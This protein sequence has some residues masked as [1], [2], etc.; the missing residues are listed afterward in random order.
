MLLF[1]GKS[2]SLYYAH[3]SLQIDRTFKIDLRKSEYSSEERRE[4]F[5]QVNK[6][7]ANSP[8]IGNIFGAIVNQG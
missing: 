7:V 2:Y 4:I 3:G 6:L 8:S 1:E 5:E